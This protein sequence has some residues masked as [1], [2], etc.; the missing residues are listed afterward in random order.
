MPAMNTETKSYDPLQHS[1]DSVH[2]GQITARKFLTEKRWHSDKSVMTSSPR[3]V[4]FS[5][6]LSMAESNVV[7][8]ALMTSSPWDVTVARRL[9]NAESNAVGPALTL[10]AVKQHSKSTA[11]TLLDGGA[12][13]PQKQ[14]K[15]KTRKPE[16]MQKTGKMSELQ[17][18]RFT[19]FFFGPELKKQSDAYFSTLQ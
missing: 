11:A 8:P 17:M 19:L 10:E 3:D 18:R 16:D 4:T 14:L 12:L 7:G 5:R 1:Y 9:S 15:P 13:K 2:A 6:R